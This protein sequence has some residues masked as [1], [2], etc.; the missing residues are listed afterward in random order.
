MLGED[1]GV[2]R[3]ERAGAPDDVVALLDPGAVLGGFQADPPFG[4]VGR[5]RG[6]DG[7]PH[8]DV[9]FDL[10]DLADAAP[11]DEPLA[12]AAPEPDA[13]RGGRR[14]V[15]VLGPDALVA[16]LTHSGRVPDHIPDGLD[17]GRDLDRHLQVMGDLSP[18]VLRAPPG[19]A[20]AAVGAGESV[21]EDEPRDRGHD[22]DHGGTI[23]FVGAVD[24]PVALEAELVHGPRPDEVLLFDRAPLAVGHARRHDREEL[25]LLPAQV[26]DQ[27]LAEPVDRRGHGGVGR[28]GT[29]VTVGSDGCGDHVDRIS[30][31]GV[32]TVHVVEECRGVR[33]SFTDDGE[34]TPVL[35]GVVAL[36]KLHHPVDVAGECRASVLVG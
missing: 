21:E 30:H 36:E 32:V 27:H 4:A 10:H 1:R 2:D 20:P 12:V 35:P 15:E 25:V 28:R 34:Q 14:A 24:Q 19:V 11:A 7:S 16:P 17:G 18:E 23:R 6:R 26:R 29:Q 13:D 8:E 9:G 5:E 3:L 31:V 33:S 22:A